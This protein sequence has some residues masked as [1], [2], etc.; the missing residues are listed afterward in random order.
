M[1][2]LSFLITLLFAVPT[3][4]VLNTPDPEF[5]NAAALWYIF[6]A[7]AVFVYKYR[8][9]SKVRYLVELLF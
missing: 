8:S 2:R 6:G 3:L 9:N 7:I 4:I 5:Y 1:M